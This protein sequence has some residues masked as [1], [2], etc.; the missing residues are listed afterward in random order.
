VTSCTLC[1]ELG[2]LLFF[3]IIDVSINVTAA[4]FLT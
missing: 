1:E 4:I 2:L 3:E